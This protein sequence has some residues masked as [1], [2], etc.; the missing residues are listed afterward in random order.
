VFHPKLPEE[1]RHQKTCTGNTEII[2]IFLGWGSEKWSVADIKEAVIEVA[3][4][5][6]KV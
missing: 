3:R 2:A 4:G 6:Y 5:E 1:H